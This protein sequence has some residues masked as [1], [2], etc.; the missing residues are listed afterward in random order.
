MKT[1]SRY[2][3]CLDVGGSH[4]T[5][6]PVDLAT[7][8]LLPA[9]RV[10][11][12][13]LHTASVQDTVQT[14]HSALTR[15]SLLCPAGTVTHLA[16]ALPAPFDYQSGVSHMTHK[17]EQLLGVNVRDVL[18]TQLRGGPLAQLPILLG[19]DADLFALGEHWAG[20]GQG[21]ERLIGITLG[22]GLGSG[23]VARGHVVTSGPEIPPAGELWNTPYADSTAEA[24][25]CG[26][27]VT[28]SYQALSGERCTA[29]EISRRADRA[30]PHAQRAFLMLGEHLAHILRP[31]TVSFGAAAV[32]V[33][34]NVS[35]AWTHFGSSLQAGLPNVQVSASQLLE[36]AALLGGGALHATPGT[37]GL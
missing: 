30:D 11:E 1:H 21:A 28:R 5:A 10:R 7:R 8:T 2:A 15:A 37:G 22:T 36:D 9:G 32:V 35:R 4:V 16:L 29:R 14:W 20:A 33:G 27:A 6:A 19:N 26:E 34:G 23:F 18:R 24:F 17:Y 3:L 25:A 13:I 31:F 12:S